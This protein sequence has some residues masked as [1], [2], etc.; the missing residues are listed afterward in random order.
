MIGRFVEK[1]FDDNDRP[2]E[3]KQY[4]GVVSD[5]IVE[6]SLYVI[7]QDDDGQDYLSD[8]YIYI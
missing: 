3:R 8:E 6:D 2:G 7:K 5:Y 1:S 4:R